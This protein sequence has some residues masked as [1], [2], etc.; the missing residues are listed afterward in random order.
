MFQDANAFELLNNRIDNDEEENSYLHHP[1]I[2]NKHEV[3]EIL[4]EAGFNA[5]HKNVVIY[6][7]PNNLVQFGRTPLI[8]ASIQGNVEV[9]QLLIRFKANLNCQN[10]Y[11]NSALHCAAKNGHLNI[12][13]LLLENKADIMKKNYV[14]KLRFI[15]QE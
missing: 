1:A 12:V 11:Q 15:V 5:N 6:Q 14:N 7:K 3:L 9:V 8:E 10:K 2:N 4:L 13:N